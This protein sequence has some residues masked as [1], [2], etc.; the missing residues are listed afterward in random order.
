MLFANLLQVMAPL[1]LR[2]FLVSLSDESASHSG[3]LVFVGLL[4]TTQ[5]GM[6]FA[7]VHYHYLGQ[8]VGS[9]VKATLTAII[10]EKSLTLSN[11]ESNNWTDG[12]IS[13]LITVDSQRI[14]SALLYANMIWSE[15]VAV[16][17]ALAILFYNL[18]WSALSGLL[19][20]GLGAKGLELSMGWLMSRRVAINAAVDHRILSLLEGLR[21]MKFVKFHAWEPYFLR[22]ISDVREAEVQQ[23]H[24]LLSLQST[25]M[26][27]STSLPSYA[28]MLS[29]IMF[30]TVNGRL[31]A[32]EAFSSLALFNCLR[33][34]LNILPMVLNQLIDAWVSI[35]RIESFLKAEDQQKTI[36]WNFD[37]VN[38]VEITNGYFSWDYA[39][40]GG[41]SSPRIDEETSL[42]G[43]HDESSMSGSKTSSLALSKVD[44]QVKPGEL[45]AVA[46][47]V[48]AGKSS[49]L[50]AL[51][52]QMSQTRGH[53]VLGATRS[54]C[55]QVPWI[56]SGTVQENILF[57]KPLLQPWYDEVVE[58]CALKP[59]LK[60]WEHGDAT[61]I[62]EQGIT[63]SGGQKQRISLA[64]TIYADTDLLL[65]DDPLSAVD[66]DIGQH[67]FNKAILALLRG[68]TCILVTHQRHIITQCDRVL[69]L[70]KGH[71]KAS[72][73]LSNSSS[74]DELL[75]HLIP[76]QE[77]YQPKNSK[78]AEHDGLGNEDYGVVHSHQD[79][80]TMID[81]ET[82]KSGSVHGSVYKT[83]LSASGSIFHWP[84][85]FSLLII[86]QIA[87]IFTSVWLSWWVDDTLGWNNRAYI[88]GYVI[89]GVVQSVLAWAYLSRASIT[90]L[91]ASD[92]LFKAA[93]RRVLYAPMSFHTA[94]PVGRLMNLF[95][96]DVSQLDNGVSGSVQAFF[97]LIGIAFSTFLLISVQFPLFILSLPVIS[98]VVYYT[99]SY[100]RASRQELKRFETVSRSTVAGNTVECIAGRQTIR[101][102]GVQHIFQ[103]RLGVAIDEA[104]NFSYLM[105]ASQQWLNLRLDTLGNVLILFVGTLIVMSD[106]SIPASMS[107][108]LMTYAIAVV[109]IIPG[110]VS[111]TAEIEN[112]FITVERMIYY[113]NEIP[114]EMSESAT[115]PPS[116]WPETGTITMKEV[117]LRYHNDHPQALQDVSLTI[118]D[119]E[120]V[121]IIGRTGAGK[122]SI[123]SVLFRLF[124][125]EH[126]SVVI[127]NM[128]IAN[129][130]PHSLRSKLAI[131]PQDPTLFQGPVRTN[132]DPSGEYPDDVLCDALRK[133]NLYPQVHLDREVLPDGKNFSLGERQL[134]ALARVLVRDPRILVCD[135]ATSAVDQDTD[136]AVQQT[137]L[138]EFQDRTV[139]CIAHRLQTIIHYDRICM[140]DQGR[141]VDFQSPLALFDTNVEFR[142]MCELNHITRKDIV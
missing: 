50:L 101:S 106:N 41:I 35:Q 100:Y 107:G 111:Q 97:M 87:G 116:T 140:I 117:S 6:S 71:I 102:F 5:M 67:I 84:I 27:L 108:L 80:N 8:V 23:Q 55:S 78:N 48:G 38:V 88:V 31:T 131:I 82:Q 75:S 125:L 130:N 95:S 54:F 113:G 115:V 9:Q 57:G 68:K 89:F 32:A 1:L 133:T 15:P 17:V 81:S 72:E 118:N 126:G 11:N 90:G 56:E 76:T 119:G 62:G 49:L 39:A 129:L 7:L 4:F 112:S 21:N 98:L 24:K 141:V 79:H 25:I 29:F 139:I 136:R 22:Q 2:Y 120:K 69:W 66:A 43:M 60:T 45:I 46:G 104:S 134:L 96:S 12:K 99:S 10:F 53:V 122:S 135:E 33:K 28:A 34:P 142:Q 19:L 51:A 123:V 65:L 3:S 70:E 26:S 128:N 91:R 124:P 138:E 20:L 121:G 16:V 73:N 77:N 114:T 44:L 13:N 58:A 93:H 92:N 14:E 47:P 86:S 52:G 110:I 64:R 36:K 59:D 74:R 85:L 42:L 137:L 30:M 132:L 63:L 103:S 40:N 37:A 105:S 109:Q 83:Y 94:N 18:T 61:Y 127:D